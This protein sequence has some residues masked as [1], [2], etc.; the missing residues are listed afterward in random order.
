MD[1][2]HINVLELLAVSN[3]LQALSRLVIGK[4]VLIQ[5]D[6]ATVVAYINRQGGTHSRS[7]CLHTMHLLSWSINNGVSLVAV[8]IPG[9]DNQIADSL[10]RG[11]S[12][13]PTEWSL[14]RAIVQQIFQ[15]LGSPQIDL[16]A[17][18]SNHQLPVYCTRVQDPQAYAVDALS[19][20][21]DGMFAYAFPPIP[22]LHQVLRKVESEDCTVV[23][24]APFWPKQ[25][26]F[27][28]LLGLLIAVP[29]LLPTDPDLLGIP[30]TQAKFH[31]VEG[32]SLTAWLLSADVIRRR[33][34]LIQQQGSWQQVDDP[35]PSRF[36]LRVCEATVSGAPLG[37]WI[38]PKHLPQR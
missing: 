10:S 29:V 37:A 31:N 12:V 28:R 38:R 26:W 7:L 1:S 19:I 36:I 20:K 6:N 23:L 21:W 5:S 35:V 16:F 4:R 11:R 24:V 2:V 18:R 14:S 9:E 8:H 33:D 34:F 13:Q 15:V 30:T 32:L 17:H 27:T 25:T 3:S 22:L